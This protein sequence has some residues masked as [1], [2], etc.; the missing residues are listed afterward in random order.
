MENRAYVDRRVAVAVGRGVDC[1][2]RLPVPVGK[3]R[4]SIG[5]YNLAATS[6][7]T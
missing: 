1:C 7:V 6:L 5:R 2:M 3:P 4:R